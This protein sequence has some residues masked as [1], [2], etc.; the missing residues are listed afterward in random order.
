M[1]RFTSVTPERTSKFDL[2]LGQAHD[3]EDRFAKILDRAKIEL[4][5]ETHL[6]ERTGNICVEMYWNG[7]PSGILVTEADFW[8]HELKREGETVV[9]LMFPVER[10]RALA[11]AS[12]KAGL[13]CDNAG[14]GG[15]STVALVPLT[16]IAS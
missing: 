2:Q 15:K 5:S 13:I 3:D 7:R 4:K 6:W 16:W 9:Y 8:V 14:D 12:L 11:F 10:L 1:S